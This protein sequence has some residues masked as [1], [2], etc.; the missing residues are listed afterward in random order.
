MRAFGLLTVVVLVLGACGDDDPEP[1]A[2]EAPSPEASVAPADD[3]SLRG[4]FVT[5]AGDEIQVEESCRDAD[6]NYNAV[7]P[8]GGSFRL[9]GADADRALVDVIP[10]EQADPLSSDPA[11]TTPVTWEGDYAT[12]EAIVYTQDGANSLEV[13]F[14]VIWGAES[15]ECDG[16]SDAITP[17][18]LYN[19]AILDD[20]LF[21]FDNICGGHFAGFTEYYAA[22]ESTETSEMLT[23]YLEVPESSEGGGEYVEITETAAGGLVSEFSIDGTVYRGRA[24]VI[25]EGDAAAAEL[26]FAMDVDGAPACD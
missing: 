23:V 16:T 9:R 3:S 26:I 20:E 21:T 18:E 6:G 24:E 11:D 25:A 22:M 12:G 10:S 1:S 2:S 8:D 5:I 4:E 19:E 7:L 13:S 14:A 15:P 17:F